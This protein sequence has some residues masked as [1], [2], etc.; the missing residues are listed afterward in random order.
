MRNVDINVLIQS[1]VW[2][3]KLSSKEDLERITRQFSKL[4]LI[5]LSHLKFY[6]FSLKL[7]TAHSWKTV[8]K[9][10]KKYLIKQN[11]I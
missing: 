6:R 2:K 9:T 7:L 4:I 10:L 8:L 1:N 11:L 3:S 5:N